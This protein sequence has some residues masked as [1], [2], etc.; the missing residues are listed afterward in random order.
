MAAAV[1]QRHPGVYNFKPDLIFALHNAGG[2]A[3]VHSRFIA[4]SMREKDVLGAWNALRTNS[5]L[6]VSS[7]AN[8]GEQTEILIRPRRRGL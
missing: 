4:V 7:P 5:S 1:K 8:A 2:W 3:L 6:E